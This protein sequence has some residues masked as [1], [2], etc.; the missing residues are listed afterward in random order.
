MSSDHNVVDPTMIALLMVGLY[1]AQVPQ[2]PN[3]LRSPGMY[4]PGEW[5]LVATPIGLEVAG[6]NPAVTY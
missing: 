3:F 2:R 6:S 5:V 4:I 1:M